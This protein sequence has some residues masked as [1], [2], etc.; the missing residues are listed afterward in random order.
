MF[1]FK[2]MENVNNK[3]GFFRKIFLFSMVPILVT[4]FSAF[5]VYNY[6]KNL[7]QN[8]IETN[9]IKTLS[10]LEQTLDNS[11][12]ELQYTTLLL[13]SD[14]NLYDI[15]YSEDKLNAL[16]QF[17][18][19][20]MMNTLVK[21]KTTKELIDSVYLLH[22]SSDE[23]LDTFGTSSSKNFYERMSQYEKYPRDFWMNLKV[24]TDYYKL[25]SPSFLQNNTEE[26]TFR[27]KVVPFVTSNIDSFKSNN[28]L[29]INISE[30]EL[31]N[32][33]NKYK[34]IQTSKMCIIN[35]QGT[36]YSNTD[37][38]I[39]E[40][41]TTNKDF[42]SKISKKNGDIFQYSINGNKN[43]VISYSSANAKFND[44]TYVAFIPYKDFYEKT[45][46]IRRLAYSLIFLGVF[47][48]MILA[49]FMSRKIYSPIDS[50]IKLLR[51]NDSD[52]LP[53][54]INEVDYLNNQINRILLNET[55]LKNDL[56]LVMPLA[57]ESYLLKILTNSDSFLD[58]DIL[59]FIDNNRINFKYENFCVATF[60]LSFTN[61]YFNTYSNDEYLLLKKGISK[62]LEKIAFENYLTYVLTISK[63]KLCVLINLT[64]K[65]I[66]PEVIISIKD[67]LNLFDYDNDLLNITAG[68]GGVYSNY[69][70]MNQSYSE[71]QK[72][73]A[74]LSPLSKDRIKIYTEENNQL[75][76]SYSIN[77][78]NKLYNYLSGNYINETILFLN[79]IIEKN[80]QNNPCEA[81]IKRLYLSI[82][83][84]IIRF[85]DEKKITA[86]K[87]MGSDYINITSELELLSANDINKYI[88]LLVNKLLTTSKLS[89]KIDVFQVT[90]YIKEHYS[91][92]I[93]LE[94]IAEHFNTSDKYLSRLFKE[95]L[96]TGFH[97]YLANIRV[98]KSK[99]LLLETNLS[100]T[101]VGEMVGFSIHST[102]FRIFKKYEGIN[103]TQYRENNK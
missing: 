65:E 47:I 13:S 33:L 17:K 59:N 77:D 98:S 12:M 96:G 24:N 51:K 36:L 82:Y 60:E 15:F 27:R 87:L 95:T 97:D 94:K 85:L 101:K 42:L 11:L 20:E 26:V 71:S 30:T 66:F 100:V 31:S 10:T 103:P 19:K 40:K 9:Y 80:Y 83:N 75:S 78:E 2:N 23:I 22:K 54:N 55:T 45:L 38:S 21:F 56:S 92:D 7:F 4:S 32:L 67:V 48:S 16:D 43:L 25:L 37:S 73:L 91:E 39:T 50:L 14:S 8:E 44:F 57:S 74:T 49:Y 89:G 35:Q 72:A 68:V 58:K 5:L 46:N 41:I 3:K 88:L 29:V 28:L 99:S 6:Y 93:Y 81:T 86:D 62:M 70:G 64:E 79:L 76:F 1:N 102:F 69:I 18:V 34:L 84:T 61:K 90:E 52:Y 53:S 63:N